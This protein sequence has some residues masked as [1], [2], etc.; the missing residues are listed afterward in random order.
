MIK[1][2]NGARIAIIQFP[3]SNSETES[4]RAVKQ[5]GM[6][7]E[8]FL[9]NRDGEDLKNFDGFFIVGG[10]SYEDR[11][12]SGIISSLDPLMDY[13]K[14]ENEKGKPI[15]GICNGAQVLVESGIVPGL[16]NYQTGVAL[17]VNK[18]MKD[19]KVLGTGFYNTWV[20]VQLST[21]SN[22]CAFSSDFKIGEFMNIPVAHAEGRFVIPT[23]LLREL[24]ENNQTVFRYCDDSGEINTDF[25]TNPNGAVYNLAAVCNSQGNAMAMM[26][27]PERTDNGQKIFTSMKKY[28]E[29]RKSTTPPVILSNSEESLSFQPEEYK[30]ENF[31]KEKDSEEL[32]IDLVITDNEA[33]TVKNALKRIGVDVEI[34][35]LSHWEIILDHSCHSE[36]V[37]E[38]QEIPKQVRDDIVEKIKLSGELY[39]SNKEIVV[40]SEHAGE[41][42]KKILVRYRDDFMGLSKKDTLTE[43]FEINGISDIKKGVIWQITAKNGNIDD[44]LSKIIESR[45]LFNQFSQEAYQI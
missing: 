1:N 21:P 5:A 30:I 4:F 20:G 13:L 25:P 26:P 37:S 19:G 22:S 38:S 3:G 45:I 36:L 6:E 27:H 15:L 2:S 41:Y 7:P 8:E 33:I 14:K 43:R 31:Q 28:I 34:K 29:K 16:K 32:L 24:K 17:A 9:W 23:E 35:K 12:R 42:T 39:N 40:P 11:S 18:R 10:F 44:V